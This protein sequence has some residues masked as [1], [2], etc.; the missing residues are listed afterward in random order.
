MPSS[1][2]SRGRPLF[3]GRTAVRDDEIEIY[4][5]ELPPETRPAGP[6]NAPGDASSDSERT[7]QGP[8]IKLTPEQ[9]LF[10]QVCSD[11][12]WRQSEHFQAIIDEFDYPPG[13][14]ARSGPKRTWT[15]A[16]MLAFSVIEITYGG[17]VVAQS[18]ISP[19]TAGGNVGSLWDKLR[20]V[21]EACWP[22]HPERRL[23]ESRPDRFKFYR[24]RMD[25]LSVETL[26]GFADSATGSA[27]DAAIHGG[28][29]QPRKGTGTNPDLSQCVPA[30]ETELKAIHN[31][32]TR[33]RRDND[34][35]PH[36][37]RD[38]TRSTA[39]TTKIVVCSVRSNFKNERYPLSFDPR[40]DRE[41]TEADIAIDAIERMRQLRPDAHIGAMIHDMAMYSKQ[42]DR[43]LDQGIHGIAKTARTPG[44]K[45]AGRSLGKHRFKR[46]DGTT[47]T[48]AV[49]ATD[50]SPN[51]FFVDS[52][53]HKYRVALDP[54]Y[55]EPRKRQKN[56]RTVMYMYWS[57]PNYPL[58]PPDLRGA[59]VRIQLNSTD[60]ER[61]QKPHRRRTAALRAHPESHPGSAQYFGRRQ[62]IES[63]F[64]TL[65]SRLPNRRANFY[66]KESLIFKGIGINH[67]FVTIATLA[68]CK[69]VGA[70][71]E[72]FFG[73]YLQLEPGIFQ[74]SDPTPQGNGAS[75][76]P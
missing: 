27:I 43:L 28:C 70:D 67:K 53:G 30:D 25:Y 47:T 8:G 23:S 22:D 42:M 55:L 45:Y 40:R 37:N 63:Y 6:N 41:G 32:K 2:S 18:L 54:R 68:Y 35:K 17:T 44:N 26:L 20:C 39:P 1:G 64:G 46:T 5:D 9:E 59:T 52:H 24:F 49:Q 62:D 75:A 16:D 11:G 51:V 7:V 21:L 58:V 74:N 13:E 73:K 14:P 57:L 72:P 71:T 76:E 12:F 19:D 61:D 36:T 4:E 31:N 50:G 38:G 66:H 60:K 29:L 34:A 65:K 3:E 33:K 69:R 48:L 15:A 10:A 56:G